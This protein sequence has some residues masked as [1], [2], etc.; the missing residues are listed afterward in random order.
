MKFR[1]STAVLI[2]VLACAYL[3]CAGWVLSALH[4]LNATGYLAA[5]A[6][7]LI[8]PLF[9]R[10][11]FSGSFFTQIRWQILCRRFRRPL[12]AI[13]LFVAV[14]TFIGGAIYPPN[15]YDALT[16]RLPRM[17]NWLAAGHWFWIPTVNARMNF[18]GTAW[19][20]TA[21]PFLALLRSDRGLFLI[22]AIGF[23]LMPGLLFCVFRQLGIARRAAWT[24]MWILPLAY[25]YATQAG[26]IGNDFVGMLFGLVSVYY[27]L[28]A[29]RSQDAKDIWL[30]ALAAALMTGTKVS[31]LPLLLP[32]LVAVWPALVHL[33]KRWIASVPV[34]A[35]AALISAAPT[36]A[37]NQINTGSWSG[38]PKNLTQVQIKSPAAALLGN[39]L[40]LLQQSFLPPILPD[41][42]KVNDWWN[43]KMP[44]SWHQTLEEKFPR[45]FLNSLN[46]LPQEETAGLGL[47]VTLLVL[48]TIVSAMCE[49]PRKN[50]FPKTSLVGLAAWIAILFFMLKMGSEAT[51][52]L[53]LPYYPLVLV[54]ILLLPVQERLSRFRPWK[55]FTVLAALS[56]LPV[57]ILSP[58]RPLWPAL[59]ASRWL[60][61]HYP[62]KSAVQRMTTVYFA[63]AHRNDALALLRDGLPGGALK[64]GFF[65]GSNDTDYSLWHPFGL[66]Q[67]EYLQIG[68]DQSVNVPG[69]IEWIVVKRDFWAEAGNVPLETWAARHH[70]KITLS[71]PIV[72]LVSRGE[73]IWCVLHIEKP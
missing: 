50:L 33:R 41:A 28:R 57:I 30:A 22:N 32:C 73:Q 19:E 66:R 64:I 51:A 56:V 34:L 5:L 35:A 20:W 53:L 52:R 31:N 39:G 47:G 43:K 72:T 37:L 17:L 1:M 46:E 69:D 6:F 48:V 67:V 65:A 68:D 8:T 60:A 27:G 58:S 23:L 13:F 54:P 10:E 55:I 16:Y 7:G 45:Y 70:A 9:W 14:M 59:S 62:D 18:S 42:H 3:N 2:W 25:G 29:R 36:M 12:P 26:G 61:R 38:D 71:V 4:E 15:N 49:F 11:N 24:W 21:M 44:T 40:L 63:Y